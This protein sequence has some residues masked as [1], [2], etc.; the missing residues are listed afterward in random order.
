[1]DMIPTYKRVE[2]AERHPAEL[3][4]VPH[5]KQGCH[6]NDPPAASGHTAAGRRLTR[7]G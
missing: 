1:M 3:L 4:P 5:T 6:E 7:R 2:G